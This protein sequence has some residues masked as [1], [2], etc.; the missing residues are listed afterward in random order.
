MRSASAARPAVLLACPGLDHAHRGF[1]TFARECFEALRGRPD[2]AIELAKASGAR[3]P[4]ERV[5]PTLTRERRAARMLARPLSRE[6]YIVEH[7][8]FAAAL[9]PLLGRLRPDVVYFS[10][11]HVGR[12]LARW[13]RASRGRFALVLANGGLMPGPYSHLD[14]VQQFVPGAIEYTVAR[15]ESADRQELLPLGVAMES[16]ARVPDQSERADVR[17][18]L[19]LP[20]DRRIVLS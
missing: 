4:D 18:R 14:R 6:P 12:V 20:R 15:G 2:L 8:A 16:E 5:V 13:R 11:W 7:V 17:A 19:G 9:I 1:E 10:E 3:G